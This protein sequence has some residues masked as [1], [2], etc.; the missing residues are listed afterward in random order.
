MHFLPSLFSI[1]RSFH[2]LFVSYFLLLKLFKSYMLF[3]HYFKMSI[4]AAIISVSTVLVCIHLHNFLTC[5]FWHC[6]YFC[7]PHLLL[8]SKEK[9]KTRCEWR[10]PNLPWR[11]I[12]FRH[13]T[14]TD[15]VYNE[16]I[17]SAF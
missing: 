16:I 4:F 8:L 6:E 10:E 14:N 15:K 17:F 13:Y 3:A 11:T 1:L 12:R 2:N 9:Y 7:L 5:N